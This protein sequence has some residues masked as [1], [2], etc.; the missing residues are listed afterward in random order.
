[1]P[2][3]YAPP[4]PDALPPLAVNNF[5]YI[6]PRLTSFTPATGY[7]NGIVTP[8]NVM[9]A[10]GPQA[11]Q[12]ASIGQPGGPRF[13][14]PNVNLFSAFNDGNTITMLGLRNGVQ[15]ASVVA[16]GSTTNYTNVP[17]PGFS[18][19]DEWRFT[20]IASGTAVFPGGAYSGVDAVPVCYPLPLPV[21]PTSSSTPTSS[22]PT[23]S[24]QTSS[25]Q[26]GTVSPSG[27]ALACDTVWSFDDL[28]TTGSEAPITSYRPSIEFPPQPFSGIGYITPALASPANGNQIYISSV[29]G[30]FPSGTNSV[31]Q[32]AE[33][34]TIGTEGSASTFTIRELT[35]WGVWRSGVSVSIQAKKNGV[36]QGSTFTTVLGNAGSASVLALPSASFEDVSTSDRFDD[37]L[38]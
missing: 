6:A 15:V 29:S 37:F 22:T 38:A 35:V 23:S 36:Q 30:I 20:T 25:T 26:T 8:E 18:D 12:A 5:F 34:G 3:T 33:S 13:S 11:S 17:L 28:A 31:I 14:I 27:A 16:L 9:F 19:I 1:M 32:I 10:A 21:V 2:A 7:I 4:N 24:T